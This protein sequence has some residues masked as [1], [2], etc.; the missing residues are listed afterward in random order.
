MLRSCDS[1]LRNALVFC[2]RPCRWSCICRR[3]TDTGWLAPEGGGGIRARGADGVRAARQ[4]AGGELDCGGGSLK[5][6]TTEVVPKHWANAQG[7]N[8]SQIKV[9][10]INLTESKEKIICCT[11]NSGQVVSVQQVRGGRSSFLWI[12]RW[13]T[14][15]GGS[16]VK[17]SISSRSNALVTSQLGCVRVR[18]LS[19]MMMEAGGVESHAAGTMTQR[20]KHLQDSQSITELHFKATTKRMTSQTFAVKACKRLCLNCSV[21]L[22]CSVA[23]LAR[24]QNT[25]RNFLTVSVLLLPQQSR[26]R[27][28]TLWL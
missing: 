11:K 15:W 13:G 5:S 22:G 16:K 14:S 8:R 7:K 9:H 28:E 25:F 3:D 24:F 26:W 4:K 19:N 17:N 20:R 2:C 10:E 21:S 12:W 18:S 1:C 27:N 6:T 23:Y